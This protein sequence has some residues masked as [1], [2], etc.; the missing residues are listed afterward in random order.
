MI[1]RVLFSLLL[2][3]SIG[4]LAQQGIITAKVQEAYSNIPL[5]GAEVWLRDTDYSESTNSMG[6]FSFSNIPYGSYTLVIRHRGYQTANFPIELDQEILDLSIIVLEEDLRQEQELSLITLTESDLGDDNTGSEATSGLLQASRD[7]YQQIAAFNWGQAR[8]RIRGLDNE[9]GMVLINGIL[10]NKLYDGRPQWGNWGGLNDVTRNQEFISG[11]K[12]VDYTFGSL[13]GVQHINTRASFQKA[14]TRLAFSGTNTNYNWRTMLTHSSGLNK[15]GWAYSLSASFRTAKEGYFEGTDY[16]AKSLFVAIEKKFNENH[17]LN[18]T[19]IY[20]QNSRG[21]N[22]PNT[23]EVNDLAGVDY[24][25]YWGWQDGKKRNSRDKDLE[26]P[27]LI[28]SHYWKWNERTKLNTNVAFQTGYI[29][30]SRIDYQNAP[31]PDPTYYRNLPSYYIGLGQTQMAELAKDKF[32][33]NKQID[34][35]ALYFANRNSQNGNSVYALYQ[36]RAEDT[37]FSA[38]TILFSDLSDNITFNGAVNYRKLKSDN[39]QKL[40][41]L[42]GGNYFL[43]IDSFYTGDAN[44]SDLQNPNR[45]IKEG[46][47]YGYNYTL[48]AD[49]IDFFTQQKF[50]YNKVDFYLGQNFSLTSYQREGKYRN[51]IYANNS[52]GKS[53]RKS[54]ESFGF[55]A[56]L[57][58]KLTANHFIDLNGIYQ[59]KAPSL[60]NTFSNVRINNIITPDLAQEKIMG[61]DLSYILRKPNLKL[62]ATGFVSQVKGATEISFYYA[63]NIGDGTGDQDAFVSEILTGINKQ[64]IGFELGAEYQITSTLKVIGGIAAGQYIYNNNPNLKLNDDEIAANGGNPL[65]DFGKAYLKNYRQPGV[66]QQAYSLGLE[67]RD[68]KFWWVGANVNYLNDTHL[69]VSNVLRTNNF[70]IDNTTG[71][72]YEGIDETAVRDLLRQEK[73]DS[74]MLVNLTGGKSWRI[75][76]KNRNTL[77]IY[78]AINNLFDYRYKT[79]GFEQSRKATYPDLYAEVQSGVRSFGPKYFYGYGRTYFVNVYINF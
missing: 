41:D 74:F 33:N 51:G 30:N 49:I 24:N 23:A 1:R 29:A 14:Q 35:N 38:N 46:D 55:K 21:K 2:F 28:L 17:S 61:A 52:L 71:I 34:W 63:E 42:L 25:S 5:Q 3:H 78:A 45:Q 48:Q 60:R 53:E 18:L 54:F 79:G 67:Y 31:N 69:D 66:P 47:K 70:T 32:L 59:T 64:N 26:E 50:N 10:M 7:T 57:T 39:F 13:L 27:I 75:S 37:Q 8:F 16:D 43:D 56:G 44:Q 73:L 15:N 20:A 72:A 9:Y 22:S 11:L 12:P 6:E 62:R 36:D 77:G 4:L 19:A 76:K 68:P 40:T 58:Y 65:I